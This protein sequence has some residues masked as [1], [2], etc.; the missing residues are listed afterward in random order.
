MTGVISL[1]V[2]L[3]MLTAP[4][5]M[6]QIYDRVLASGSV[7]TL[8]ALTV[9]AGALLVFLG[10]L[11]LMRSRILVRVG[12]GLDAK[13]GG[14]VLSALLDRSLR[15]SA[16]ARGQALRDLD[17]LRQFLT[18]PGPFALF[19]APWAPMFLAVLFLFHPL[20]GLVAL[21]GGV[22][23]FT[24]A[25][26]TEVLTNKPLREAS[27]EVAAANAFAETSLRN[28]DTLSALGM[29]P[30]I[31]RRWQA[32]HRKGLGLQARASDRSG[33]LLA[34]SKAIRMFLQVAML[35]T[36]AVLAIEQIITPGM[37]IAGS[38]VMSRAL[39]PVEQAIGQWRGFIG[40]RGA[41]R[42][43]N[44]LL[45][46]FPQRRAST[47]LPAPQGRLAVERLFVAPPGGTAPI[48]KDVCFHLEAGESLGVI[49][50]SAAGK[51][52]LARA[53]VG[54]WQPTS[55]AVRLDGA[56]LSAWHREDLGRHT[57]YLPQGVE[58]FEG[59]VGENIA[60]LEESPEA[61]R[62]VEAARGAGAH[63]LILRLPEAYDTRIGE[64][65]S[66]L[67]GGQ[68]QRI[69]LARAL[70]G[71]PALVVLDEPNANLDAAGDE[72]LT[73]AIL[74]LKARGR[75]VIVMAH[76]PSAIVAVD[77]LLMLGDGKV[78]AF[79][80]KEQVLAQVTKSAGTAS[81]TN[82]AAIRPHHG[83]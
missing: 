80:P 58:L 12:N 57:G 28:S 7:P 31:L 60:R 81:G 51:S 34:S 22:V 46:S 59:T 54:S 20:M 38:I 65:G 33:A 24:I 3:L 2:N 70:Y 26:L 39:A 19:D 1:F 47:K 17:S 36:G 21:C 8:V 71:D 77:K 5:Y 52:T 68:R 61:E 62:I 16:G 15:I 64:G 49:G 76:R 74:G 18:G 75:T 69:G 83:A 56:E 4:L 55:G 73:H 27:Q 9:L 82:V 45:E 23:L 53:L 13:L 43:L 29:L 67:S 35:G 79:G 63:E 32:Q 66:V 37:M 48:L 6:L 78:Q 44:D 14:R 50:P 10:L 25:V 40:A 11:E 42:R 30:A 41:Y 72:A